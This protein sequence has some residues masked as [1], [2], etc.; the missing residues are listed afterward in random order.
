MCHDLAFS[1]RLVLNPQTLPAADLLLSKLQ[2]V[3]MTDRD[4]LDTLAILSDQPMSEGDEAGIN[5]H[6]VAQ[7]CGGDW[8]WWRTTTVNLEKVTTWVGG[9][10]EGREPAVRLRR[11]LD[12]VPKSPRW[13]AR[14]ILGDRKRWYDLPEEVR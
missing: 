9:L 4:V 2:I 8:G 13:R 3:E 14:A 6:R 7:V 12:D 10:G 11:F 5:L 1:R